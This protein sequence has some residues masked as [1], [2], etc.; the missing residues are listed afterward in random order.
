MDETSNMLG[1][2]PDG[3]VMAVLETTRMTGECN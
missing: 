3:Q 2:I 1:D